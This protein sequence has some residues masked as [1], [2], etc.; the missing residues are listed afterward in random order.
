M[1]ASLRHVRCVRCDARVAAKLA[2]LFDSAGPAK[3]CGG[4]RRGE[5]WAVNQLGGK[6]KIKKSYS[7]SNYSVNRHREQPSTLDPDP[8]TAKN[9]GFFYSKAGPLTAADASRSN[10]HAVSIGTGETARSDRHARQTSSQARGHDPGPAEGPEPELKPSFC[11]HRGAPHGWTV[12]NGD[13]SSWLLI[14]T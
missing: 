11:P 8:T 14:P 5:M 3:G 9:S 10:E 2:V 13:R 6:K 4:E 7:R 1:H 12:T